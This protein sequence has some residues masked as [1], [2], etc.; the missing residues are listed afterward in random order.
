MMSVW[1]GAMMILLVTAGAIAISFTDFMSDRLYGKKRVFF[2]ILLLSY[3]VY[4]GFRIRQALRQKDQDG[5]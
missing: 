5:V 4:R 3:A 1:F 2:V